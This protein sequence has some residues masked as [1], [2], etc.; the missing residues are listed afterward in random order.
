MHLSVLES[1]AG[2]SPCRSCASCL[3]VCS[4]EHLNLNSLPSQFRMEKKKI[5]KGWRDG[6]LGKSTQ[7][8]GGWFP[9]PTWLQGD[10]ML[11][12]GLPGHKARVRHIDIHADNSHTH[13]TQ[14][15][16]FK[17]SE[18]RADLWVWGMSSLGSHSIFMLE[19]DS[20]EKQNS[21]PR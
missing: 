8:S 4:R 7:W 18:G 2:W 9:A 16:N 3:S 6:S 13:K 14:M 11:S 15:S 1:T 5:R 17:K 20:Q 10:L 12:R 21:V 19:F